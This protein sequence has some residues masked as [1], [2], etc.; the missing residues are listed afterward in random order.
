[1]LAVFQSTKTESGKLLPTAFKNAHLHGGNVSLSRLR[2]T[3]RQTF[4]AKVVGPK[5]SDPL[6]GVV[7]CATSVLRGLLVPLPNATPP[8]QI[9][10]VCVLD[11]VEPLDYDGHAALEY[12]EDQ[13]SITNQ[14]TK[15]LLRAGIAVALVSAFGEIRATDSVFT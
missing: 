14:Q 2:Y 7:T 5:A 11:K 10:A 9:R 4:D 13:Q 3:T 12:C 1:M 6:K 15:A 8:A